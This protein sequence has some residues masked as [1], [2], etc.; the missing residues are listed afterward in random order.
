MTKED[1]LE[2]GKGI[3]EGMKKEKPLNKF[4][5]S[6]LVSVAGIFS[7]FLISLSGFFFFPFWV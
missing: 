1:M 3:V 7:F 2:V 6:G 4:I 5:E